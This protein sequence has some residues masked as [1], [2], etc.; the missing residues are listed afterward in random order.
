MLEMRRAIPE[1]S[2]TS[3]DRSTRIGEV[4]GMVMVANA[5]DPAPDEPCFNQSKHRRNPC[6]CT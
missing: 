4:R 2:K 3:K 5:C 6:L 1:R